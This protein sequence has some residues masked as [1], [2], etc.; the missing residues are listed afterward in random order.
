VPGPMSTHGVEASSGRWKD[1][2]GFAKQQRLLL[3]LPPPPP[4]PPAVIDAAI[5]AR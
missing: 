5:A 2:V 1:G 3:L 4:P